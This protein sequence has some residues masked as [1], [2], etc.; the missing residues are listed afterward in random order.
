[1]AYVR[2]H[3]NQV[4]IVHGERDPK[5][6]KVAQRV[7]F[8]FY[9]R[10]EAEEALRHGGGSEG[11]HFQ[12][13]L[14]HRYPKVSLDWRKIEK[15]IKQNLGAL[16]ETH[17][18]RKEEL[19]E[20]FRRDLRAFAR[21]VMLTDPQLLSSAADLIRGHRHELEYLD[22]LIRWRL[23]TCPK[24][25]KEN[26]WNKDNRFFWRFE[27]QGGDVPPGEHEFA[28]GFYH[29]G[30]LD[31]AKAGFRLLTECF[32]DYADGHNHL[33]DIALEKGD[34]NSALAHFRRAVEIGR[35]LFPKRMAKGRYW[36]DYATRPYMRGLINLAAALNQAERYSEALEVCDRLEK[37]CGDR[38]SSS[39]ER[40]AIYLNT[41]R[42]REAAMAAL[43]VNTL[44]P[45][46]GFVAAFALHEEGK[47]AEAVTWFLHGAL[48]FPRAARILLGFRE[49]K[50]ESAD[51]ARDHNTGVEL[52][53][54]LKAYMG[55]RFPRS[56]RFFE[57]IMNSPQVDALLDETKHVV[58][59]RA[60]QHAGKGKQ[61]E[62]FDRMLQMRTSDYAKERARE[63]FPSLFRNGVER[64]I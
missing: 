35:G 43:H 25:T 47:D 4:A 62:A 13:L 11:H 7:L 50:V 3:G 20:E 55:N 33:G 9:S 30:Q 57:K 15:G 41:G 24:T 26:V 12:G 38:V 40:G 34:V 16:P 51:E 6:K 64:A 14:A 19:R 28:L 27:L 39:I 21:R 1:M 10:E 37:E 59:R 48:N 29:R 44:F 46:E 31:R 2:I 42:W 22:E 56:R 5:T 54:R 18:D 60:H 61:R 45:A 8:R 17:R 52:A 23:K 63:I 53:Q 58:R 36:N 32:E 49:D